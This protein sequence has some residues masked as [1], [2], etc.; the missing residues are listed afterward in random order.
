MQA[1]TSFSSDPWPFASDLA[2]WGPED[3]MCSGSPGPWPP[4]LSA[5]DD[6]SPHVPAS[7]LLPG[8]MSLA[9]SSLGG[10]SDTARGEALNLPRP[11][12]RRPSHGPSTGLGRR[13]AG[14]QR[15]RPRDR[16]PLALLP[17]MCHAF[18]RL[19]ALSGGAHLLVEHPGVR[20][21]ERGRG[22]CY[23]DA[24]REK[25]KALSWGSRWGC[26][27]RGGTGVVLPL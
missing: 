11:P 17:A 23:E 22:G 1:N 27:S 5:T 16:R 3:L 10:A 6:C 9:V 14:P 21:R 8:W 19:G 7:P 4:R 13:G 26:V 15:L 24:Q 18:S 2:S 25:E 20:G 12:G